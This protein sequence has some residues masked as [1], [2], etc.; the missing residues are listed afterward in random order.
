MEL[1]TKPAKSFLHNFLV[2]CTTIFL[3]FAFLVTLSYVPG[4]TRIFAQELRG[5]E[6]GSVKP[7]RE[8]VLGNA[9]VWGRCNVAV[10]V[11]PS[12]ASNEQEFIDLVDQITK[13]I[14]SFGGVQ[15]HTDMHPSEL[16]PNPTLTKSGDEPILVSLIKESDPVWQLTGTDTIAAYMPRT[17]TFIPSVYTSGSVIIKTSWYNTHT[18]AFR[19]AV[20]MH[21]FIHAAGVGHTSTTTLMSP[22]LAGSAPIVEE[23][24]DAVKAQRPPSCNN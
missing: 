19:V 7:V 14:S 9:T 11:N 13:D 24:L 1:Q 4:P 10:K 16:L 5:V 22:K 18:I 20:I 23:I 12:G 3:V 17:N 2:F 15:L 6:T 8:N 21:E